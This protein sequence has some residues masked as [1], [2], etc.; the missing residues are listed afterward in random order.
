M[1][2]ENGQSPDYATVRQ[3]LPKYFRGLKLMR[4][5][6]EFGANYLKSR[7]VGK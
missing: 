1:Q 3:F 2:L 6:Q 7:N 4:G 5:F